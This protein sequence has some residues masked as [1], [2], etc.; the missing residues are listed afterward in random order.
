M[1]Q[2]EAN[3]KGIVSVADAWLKDNNRDP[4]S[5]RASE[6]SHSTPITPYGDLRDRS[7]RVHGMTESE[8]KAR[9]AEYGKE[10]CLLKP[11]IAGGGSG[12]KDG[13]A[14]E[15]GE[16]WP[17]E[18]GGL[19]PERERERWWGDG[20]LLLWYLYAPSRRLCAQ[21]QALRHGTAEF[22]HELAQ[23]RKRRQ[24][25]EEWPDDQDSLN[26]PPVDVL[27]F[28]GRPWPLMYLNKHFY[29]AYTAHVASVRGG[30]GSVNCRCAEASQQHDCCLYL[31]L[32][33]F[34]L[35]PIIYMYIFAPFFLPLGY[36]RC[37]YDRWYLCSPSSPCG[38]L[39]TRLCSSTTS[40]T[41]SRGYR[42]M[43]V[44]I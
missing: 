13:G 17:W 36:R 35:P 23:Q 9:D 40:S 2:S 33:L 20:R 8:L 38:Q 10:L 25:T 30:G 3:L 29:R 43:E 27:N 32:I 19:A 15:E 39:A 4:L 34:L 42:Q 5:R 31:S 22:A 41:P 24:G 28:L 21:F 7:Y 14:G 12:G 37:G 6:F 18:A 11:S 26:V 1:G 16:V 44:R